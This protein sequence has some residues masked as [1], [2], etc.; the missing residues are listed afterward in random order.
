MTTDR[1]VMMPPEPPDKEVS[2]VEMLICRRKRLGWCLCETEC[3]EAAACRKLTD[4][5]CHGTGR[6]PEER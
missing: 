6:E 2:E 3:H 4:L 1:P 5:G